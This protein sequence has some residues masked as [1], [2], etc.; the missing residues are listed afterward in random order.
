MK[1]TIIA[2]CALSVLTISCAQSDDSKSSNSSNSCSDSV[3]DARNALSTKARS[4]SSYPTSSG[5]REVDA[6]CK[7][8]KAAI[9]DSKCLATDN[10]T[11]QVIEVSYSS[12]ASAC[13]DIAAAA[14][15]GY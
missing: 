11:G 14:G 13:A 2:L 8:Y 12:V 6:A 1:K 5:L 15:S 3:I 4:Y 7:A 9:G 10:S